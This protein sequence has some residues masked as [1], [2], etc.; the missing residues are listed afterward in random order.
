[1]VEVAMGWSRREEKNNKKRKE[2]GEAREK[3]K[4]KEKKRKSERGKAVEKRR[5]SSFISVFC[6]DAQPTF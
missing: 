2:R 5:L 4:G 6:V 1:M 3:G